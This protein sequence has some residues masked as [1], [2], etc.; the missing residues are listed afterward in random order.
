M[1]SALALNQPA[2]RPQ[3]QIMASLDKAGLDSK[4]HH[5]ARERPSTTKLGGL[6]SGAEALEAEGMLIG[7]GNGAGGGAG[8]GGN[9]GP[10]GGGGSGGSTGM[11][12]HHHGSGAPGGVT[13]SIGKSEGL[14]A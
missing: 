7:G 10:T 1:R 3:M 11:Y 2:P 8:G 4:S 5:M 6:M 12:Q 9:Q 13:A 14:A